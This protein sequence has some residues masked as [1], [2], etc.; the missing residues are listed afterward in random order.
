MLEE[1]LEFASIYETIKDFLENQIIKFR[2]H[3]LGQTDLS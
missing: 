2:D 3:V 1:R